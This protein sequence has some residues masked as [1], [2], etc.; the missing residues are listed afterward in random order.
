LSSCSIPRSAACLWWK[1]A[2]TERK[3]SALVTTRHFRVYL[4]SASFCASW[5]LLLPLLSISKSSQD[6]VKTTKHR[7]RILTR[8]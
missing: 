5:S 6:D 7:Q 1:G 3:L 4:S 2:A 8:A